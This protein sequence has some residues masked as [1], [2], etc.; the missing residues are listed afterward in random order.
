V[1][2]SPLASLSRRF[3]VLLC[4]PVTW[5]AC[6]SLSVRSH[7]VQRISAQVGQAPLDLGCQAQLLW[8]ALEV[9]ES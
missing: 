6:A 1:S 8:D 5:M 2:L 4:R 3:R 7:V 9:G